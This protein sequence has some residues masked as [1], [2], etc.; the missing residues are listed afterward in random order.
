VQ[1]F[2]R[3]RFELHP[4]KAAPY[5]V[6][7]GLLGVQQSSAAPV[8]PDSFQSR[9]KGN[10]YP[11][12]YSDDSADPGA[13]TLFPKFESPVVTSIAAA[14]IFNGLFAAD[15]KDNLYPQ[16]AWYVPSLENGGAY[17]SGVGDDRHLA[18]KYKLRQ[19]INGQTDRR[20]PRRM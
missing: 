9:A 7:L 11:Q 13:A 16:V 12:R 15:H 3:N 18:V 6:E 1:Y 2:Q 8:P 14:P 19:G 4:E 20:L 5:E 17:W 10:D